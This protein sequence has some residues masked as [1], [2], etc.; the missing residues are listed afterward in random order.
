MLLRIFRVLNNLEFVFDKQNNLTFL[1]YNGASSNPD[2]L[3]VSINIIDTTHRTVIED[4]SSDP[5][6]VLVNIDLQMNRAS[7]LCNRVSSNFCKTNWP[8]I[9]DFLEN[10]LDESKTDFNQH[11]EKIVTGVNIIINAAKKFLSRG[12]QKVFSCFWIDDL[13]KLKEER[14]EL[15]DKTQEMQN[16]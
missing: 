13:I 1:H 11:P 2:L 12:R 6:M 10:G 15:R 16:P 4:C 3:M 7:R 9:R 8:A 14:D 5:F